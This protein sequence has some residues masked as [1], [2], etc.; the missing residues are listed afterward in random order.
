MQ[1]DVVVHFVMQRGF[2]VQLLI[3]CFFGG[4]CG[5]VA[6]TSLLSGWI[7]LQPPSNAALITAQWLR[8]GGGAGCAGCNPFLA[9]PSQHNWLALGIIKPVPCFLGHG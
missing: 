5:A 7:Y 4:V 9:A 8:V 2:Y 3:P 6:F 1:L